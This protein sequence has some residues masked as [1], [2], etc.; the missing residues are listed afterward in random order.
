M[1]FWA[2]LDPIQVCVSAD[3]CLP[4]PIT[5]Q[6]FCSLKV[7]GHTKLFFSGGEPQ[8]LSSLLHTGRPWK[9]NSEIIPCWLLGPHHILGIILALLT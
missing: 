3:P 8:D 5:V 9:A 7:V 1:S 6:V 4:P 2:S